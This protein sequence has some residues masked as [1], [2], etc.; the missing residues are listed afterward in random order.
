VLLPA[1]PLKVHH[2]HHHHHHTPATLQEAAPF[3]PQPSGAT[4]EIDDTKS[5]FSQGT[6]PATK[7][8][9]KRNK[10]KKKR[11]GGGAASVA[12]PA[13]DLGEGKEGE[14][15]SHHEDFFHQFKSRL[16]LSPHSLAN[17]DKGMNSGMLVEDELHEMFGMLMDMVDSVPVSYEMRCFLGDP[18][19]NPDSQDA[20]EKRRPQIEGEFLQLHRMVCVKFLDFLGGKDEEPRLTEDRDH[21]K[22]LAALCDVVA[23]AASGRNSDVPYGVLLAALSCDG[24][25]GRSFMCMC[26]SPDMHATELLIQLLCTGSG[27]AVVNDSVVDAL[28]K[29]LG[30]FNESPHGRTNAAKA[31]ARLSIRIPELRAPTIEAIAASLAE[32][33]SG[34]LASID[35]A[36][37]VAE[38]MGLRAKECNAVVRKAFKKGR[39]DLGLYGGYVQYL[40]GVGLP[41]DFDDKVVS[42]Q[43]SSPAVWIHK[44]ASTEHFAEVQEANS[45]AIKD[46]A[47]K[48]NVSLAEQENGTS[49]VSRKACSHCGSKPAPGAK[50][51]F[52]CARCAAAQYCGKECQ[53]AAWKAGHKRVCASRERPLLQRW[54]EKLPKKMPWHGDSLKDTAYVL[55]KLAIT[56]EFLVGLKIGHWPSVMDRLQQA[57]ADVNIRNVPPLAVGDRVK[58]FPGNNVKWHAVGKTGTLEEYDSDDGKWGI[59]LESGDKSYIMKGNLKRV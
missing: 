18:D 32:D 14:G 12:L 23:S 4:N 42:E 38:L 36:Q 57:M 3:S 17:L 40:E 26:E 6:P 44:D 53:K 5:P 19:T 55:D 20:R 24:V 51:F 8:K 29:F 9:K 50:A 46:S 10:K 35:R 7:K 30:D 27:G 31:L 28:L 25:V 56:S 54:L 16:G 1:R 58:V 41:V 45:A 22:N 33:G 52:Q 2:H 37:L 47:M 15:S 48:H 43:V 49:A 13:V 34:R 39:V 11:G 59:D 21:P